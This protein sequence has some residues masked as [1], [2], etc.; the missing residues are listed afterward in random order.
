MDFRIKV[1]I[2]N[3]VCL[4]RMRFAAKVKTYCQLTIYRIVFT[5]LRYIVK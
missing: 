3:V 2:L 4:A 5:L 1:E